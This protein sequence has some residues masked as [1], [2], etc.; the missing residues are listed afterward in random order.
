MNPPRF[1]IDLN[2]EEHLA[3]RK[4]ASPRGRV[5]PCV[6]KRMF[7]RGKL[8]PLV[9]MRMAFTFPTNMR[10]RAKQGGKEEWR[11]E[12][13]TVYMERNTTMVDVNLPWSVPRLCGL[14]GRC[15]DRRTFSL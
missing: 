1:A 8:F 10:Q 12:R 15:D 9:S 2:L 7:G 13:G 4:E 6:W 3:K 5:H 11:V 14:G